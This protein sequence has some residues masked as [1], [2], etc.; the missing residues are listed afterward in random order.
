MAQYTLLKKLHA[1]PAVAKLPKIPIISKKLDWLKFW[2]VLQHYLTKGRKY[3]VSLCSPINH[4]ANANDFNNAKQLTSLDDD[5]ISAI[6]NN[7]LPLFRNTGDE[8][9]GKGS[10]KFPNQ[11]LANITGS[12]SSGPNLVPLAFDVI[13]K[14]THGC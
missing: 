6:Q 10:R 7:A 13:G 2:R 9:T 12:T 14:Y 3:L 4:V 1:D 5:L 8:Y 11:D